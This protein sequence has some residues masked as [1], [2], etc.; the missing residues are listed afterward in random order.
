MKNGRNWPRSLYVAPDADFKLISSMLIGQDFFYQAD[1]YEQLRQAQPD[2]EEICSLFAKSRDELQHWEEFM[3]HLMLHDNEI[4]AMWQKKK[5]EAANSGT[6][7]HSMLEHLLNGYEILPGCMRGELNAAIGILGNMGP[8]EIFRTE[9]AIHAPEEDV[10]GSID[11][12]LKRKNS[13][14]FILVDWKRSEKLRDK[15]NA[16]GRTM[17]KPIEHVPDCQGE[18]YR[19]QLNAYRWIL[20]KYYDIKVSRML[21]VCVHPNY[22]PEG[23]VDEVPDLQ[24]SIDKI[25]ESRRQT[26]LAT[27]TEAEQMTAA[28]EIPPT[29]PFEVQLS[30]AGGNEDP[31]GEEI[32]EALH[33]ILEQ[34]LPD[35]PA[36]AKKRRLQPGADTHVEQFNKFFETSH[37]AIANVLT[38]YPPDVKHDRVEIVRRT[39]DSLAELMAALPTVSDELRRLIMA[40]RYLS[41]KNVSDK[42]MLADAAAFLWLVEGERH[43]RVHDGFLN[44]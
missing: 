16:Y 3:S 38:R 27:A 20:E 7:M 21:V 28:Q 42:L 13:D 23:F 33:L 8:V 12:V 30:G 22:L 26:L 36:G 5:E 6:W 2:V 39:Q 14:D 34:S 15:Y 1:L 40:A 37:S 35:V 44:I 24:K 43:I 10:A 29:V 17:K 18:Q 31:F 32:A 11:V 4:E 41:E 9:W 25:M 19:L